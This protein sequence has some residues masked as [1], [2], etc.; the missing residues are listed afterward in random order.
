LHTGYDPMVMDLMTVPI[1]RSGDDLV[2]T[3]V[4]GA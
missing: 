2:L 1:C 3:G 4:A